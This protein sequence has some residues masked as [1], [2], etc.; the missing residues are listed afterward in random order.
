MRK[1]KQF[2]MGVAAIAALGFGVS[3]GAAQQVYPAYITAIGIS[4]NNSTGE[5]TYQ[6]WGNQDILRQCAE[7]FGA[8]NLMD[9]SLV[10]NPSADAL[11][12]LNKTNSSVV[13]T[14]RR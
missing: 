14:A 8:S 4:T 2:I 10:Y 3:H 5:L 7:D 12:V 1:N 6:F 9:A 13:S 11:P